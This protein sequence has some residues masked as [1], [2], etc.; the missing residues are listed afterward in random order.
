[1]I[2][3]TIFSSINSYLAIFNTLKIG[4]LEFAIYGIVASIF[5][6]AGD[7]FASFIKRKNSVKD[8]GKIFPGHGGFMDRVDGISFNAV[9]TFVF[10]LFLF[11]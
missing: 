7:I 6:Q 4:I 9:F 3:F 1:M 11:V 2:L 5:S 10:L 8:Y